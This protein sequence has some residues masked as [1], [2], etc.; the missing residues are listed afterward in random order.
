MHKEIYLDNILS[1]CLIVF[2]VLNMVVETFTKKT[3]QRNHTWLKK[4]S[5]IFM[6]LLSF[7]N[8]IYLF[9][10]VYYKSLGS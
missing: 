10:L 2:N 6:V 1:V 5:D 4:K 7:T 8:S 3:K 9:P